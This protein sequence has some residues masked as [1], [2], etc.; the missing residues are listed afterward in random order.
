MSGLAKIKLYHY[1]TLEN[2]CKRINVFNSYQELRNVYYKG[3]KYPLFRNGRDRD[4]HKLPDNTYVTKFPIYRDI[5]INKIHLSEDPLKLDVGFNK[6]KPVIIKNVNGEVIAEF[7][8]INIANKL[9][10]TSC[11]GY[12]RNKTKHRPSNM[13][14][15][16]SVELK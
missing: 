12:L 4:I 2:R 11:N 6:I 5:L 10:G 8:N 1:D 3:S 16:I 7:A 15:K 14:Y 13:L 9:L